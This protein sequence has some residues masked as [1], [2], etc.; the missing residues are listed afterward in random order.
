VVSEAL[1]NTQTAHAKSKATLSTGATERTN[2]QQASATGQGVPS[3]ALQSMQR[4]TLSD[5]ARKS[6]TDD[7]E[8]ESTLIRQG[9]TVKPTFGN[10]C[11]VFRHAPEFKGKLRRNLMT[12]AVEF[13]GKPLPE[14]K[15][16]QI[17][18]RCE[19]APWG[20][21]SPEKG[22][23]FDAIYT[24]ASERT[25]HPV[26]EYLSALEWDGD[27]RIERVITDIFGTPTSQA[28]DLDHAMVRKWFIAAVRR[29]LHPGIKADD[30]LVLQ[31]EQGLKKSTFFAILG[32]E[33]FGDTEVKIGDKD[34]LQQIHANWITEWGEIDRITT[35]SHAGAVK[36]FISRCTDHFRPPY[37]RNVEPYKR[38]CVIVGSV[39][40]ERFLTDP[41]GARRFYVVRVVSEINIKLLTE[42]RDQ[43]WAEAVWL[44]KT[45]EEHYLTG[46][47]ARAHKE[48]VQVHRATDPFESI[49]SAWISDVWPALQESTGRVYLQTIDLML[50]AL[51]LKPKD[52][53]KATEMRV[54]DAMGTIGYRNKRVRLRKSEQHLYRDA[55]GAV[56]DRVSA[57]IPASTISTKELDAADE[58]EFDN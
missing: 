29:A 34:G 15:A 11:K 3:N 19:D 13:D 55:S 49:L 48:A 23:M 42:W 30:A 53:T 7:T 57:W 51:E 43:L 18:E 4:V 24:V 52:C 6:A 33:W 25:Y 27:P 28:R 12:Q 36:S 1:S 22:T 21:F 14:E 31:G 58:I 16:G 20:G 50:Y 2:A 38:S 9:R 46:D 8:W 5:S 54:A 47:D 17:R 26:R 56:K 10:L 32:G 35:A 40:P 37:A 44:S 41:T 45:D 39:N